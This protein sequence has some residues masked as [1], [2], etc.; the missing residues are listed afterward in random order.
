LAFPGTTIPN[1]RTNTSCP[2]PCPANQHYT[3]CVSGCPATCANTALKATCNKPCV[4]G[5]TCEDG[6]VLDG[7]GQKCIPQKNCGCKDE[8]GNYFE[9]GSTWMNSQC[10]KA[11]QCMGNNNLITKDVTCGSKGY[12][13]TANNQYQCSC[14]TGSGT[15]KTASQTINN[16]NEYILCSC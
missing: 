4:E 1:W 2:L 14:S 3:E 6:T 7:S 11:Y 8:Q 13:S 10:T 9:A 15:C 12:C 5:C 16:P